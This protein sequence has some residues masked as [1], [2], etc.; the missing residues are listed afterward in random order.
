MLLHVKNIHLTTLC[1][2]VLLSGCS[3]F[4]NIESKSNTDF[5]RQ[6]PLRTE[7]IERKTI[8]IP[9]GIDESESKLA[10]S[11]TPAIALV[12]HP[13]GIVEDEPRGLKDGPAIT[14]NFNQMPLPAF[15]NEV[16]L[17]QLGLSYTLDPGLSK[18][19]DLVTL[20]LAKPQSP[21]DLF[22]TAKLV[23]ADYGVSIRRSGEILRFVPDIDA[24]GSS[25]PL[26]ISGRALPEVPPSHRPVFSIIPLSA[27]RT[28]QV[29]RWVR[30]LYKGTNLELFEDSERNAI[31][32]KGA[33]DVVQQVTDSIKMLD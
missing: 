22:R 6:E 30:E 11:E 18:K 16:F 26:L 1:A 32:V 3:S 5:K 19:S 14:V 31:L 27:L 20:A 10:V 2:I 4:D 15:I 9:A 17:K 13:I 24:S 7:S 21:A 8:T 25:V 12:S 23:L 29:K 33:V 28:P